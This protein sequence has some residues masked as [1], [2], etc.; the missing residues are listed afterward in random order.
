MKTFKSF[1][2]AAA[3]VAVVSCGQTSKYGKLGEEVAKDPEVAALSASQETV[4]SVSY[5]LG[6]NY[7]LMFKGNGFFDNISEVNMKQLQKGIE[8]ALA[9]GEPANQYGM[10]EEWAKLFEVSPYD[11]NAILNGFLA[12]RRAYQ[13]TFNQK[14]GEKFLENNAKNPNV[15][16]TESGLQYILHAEGEDEKVQPQDRVL[17]NYKGTL[18]DGTEFDAND[19]TEFVANRVIKGWTEGLGL[20]GKGGKATLYIPS[21]LAYGERGAG[22]DIEPNSTL[23]FEVEVIDVIKPEPVVEE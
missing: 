19:S 22:R 9:A 18:I 4:D 10:D 1:A 16:V 13:M 7:G 20:L 3:L 21:E 8:D 23:I 17:V 15:Q 2:I 11:M 14:L 6:V 5:L 12:N